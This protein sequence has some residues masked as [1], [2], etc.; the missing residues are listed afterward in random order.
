LGIKKYLQALAY[1]TLVGLGLL[2]A[3]AA[4]LDIQIRHEFEG[5]R[6]SLPARV[7][8]RPLE[9]Y[10]GQAISQ[11]RII[12][13]LKLLRY[14]R[15]TESEDPGIYF[16]QEP[17]LHVNT[18]G[19]HF[20]DGEEPARQLRIEFDDELLTGIFDS[21]SNDIGLIRLEPLHIAN[22]YPTHNEDRILVRLDQV[23]DLLK[24]GLVAVEDRRFYQHSGVDVAALVRAT[25]ANIKAGKMVQGG[26][27]L[28]QQLVKNYFLTNEQTIWR[29]FNEAIMSILL[30]LHYSKD[31]VLQAY[32]NEIYLGQDGRRAIHGFALASRFYFDKNLAELKRQQIALLI[33]L[34]KGPSFYNPRTQPLHAKQRRDLVLNMLVERQVLEPA[35]ATLA[36]EGPLGVVADPVSGVGAYPSFVELVRQQLK[37]NY[38]EDVIRSEGLV[39]HS[40]LDPQ[41]Q[42]TVESSVDTRLQDLQVGL[43]AEDIELQSA[44][45][46]TDIGH[47]E[48][49]ALTG[50]RTKDYGGFNRAIHAQRPIGS[51]IKPVVYLTALSMPETY[52]LATYLEDEPFTLELQNDESW[53]PRNYD[54]TYHGQ[55]LLRDALVYSYNVSTARLGLTIGLQPIIHTLH[56]LG[57]T[58]TVDQF[59]SLLLGAIELSP[60]EVSQIYQTIAARGYMTPLTA[61]RGVMDR[62]GQ[63]MQNFPLHLQQTVDST[64]TYILITA[65]HEITRQGTAKSLQSLLPEGLHVAGKTGTTNDLRDSWFAGYSGEHLIVVWLGEDR[66]KPIGLTGA[67]GALQ[68]WADIMRQTPTKSLKLSM[69]ETVEWK[70]INTEEG[71][72]ASESCPSAEWM[73]FVKGSGP[74]EYSRCAR[75]LGGSMKNWFKE[76]FN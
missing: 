67:S 2:C 34:V 17:N 20:W 68:L 16:V 4:Y 24:Q 37:I 55:V 30:E 49:L 9:L 33:A 18:R 47:G 40:T 73:P 69:P 66:N 13:E 35:K 12:Q 27:T 14:K 8:A 41:I 58:K 65:M 74:I 22:I 26:S 1:T 42:D 70:L 36:S 25:L 64:A 60:L 19:F 45:V 6:W 63:L 46:V 39:I 15:N 76:L 52:T 51:L 44:V 71:L 72:L 54:R 75:G 21:Y 61:I 53:S 32:I 50:G 31:E 38:P 23:P 28:T 3:Y 43:S 7:Y 59:P 57:Y 10:T 5:K 62:N 48:V 29:K 56:N 11:A